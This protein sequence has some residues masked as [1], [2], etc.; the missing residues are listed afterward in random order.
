MSK[1]VLIFGATGMT[2]GVTLRQAVAAGHEVTAFVRNPELLP[3]DLQVRGVKGDVLDTEAVEAAVKDQDVVI[4]ALG[5]RN[6]LSPTTM[7]SEGTHNITE[8]MKV[9]GVHRV[10]ACLSSFLFWET[11]LVPPQFHPLTEDHRRMYEV[12]RLSG[13]QYVAIMPPHIDGDIFTK[14]VWRTISTSD[15][16]DRFSVFV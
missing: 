1:K 7:M 11:N 14:L 5:T 4:I 12:L 6:D 9:H 2:G 3:S 8:A 15:E 10:I 16:C 13:L